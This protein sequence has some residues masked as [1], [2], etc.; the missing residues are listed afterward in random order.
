[1]EY[2]AIV[3]IASIV[4]GNFLN[5]LLNI[6]CI[7]EIIPRTSAV[8]QGVK[9]GSKFWDPA[10]D[11][12]TKKFNLGWKVRPYMVRL[13]Y[14]LVELGVAIA[15]LFLLAGKSDLAQFVRQ[16]KLELLATYGLVIVINEIAA[17]YFK[18]DED[19]NFFS[20]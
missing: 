10:A 5:S 14:L 15:I 6:L 12:L 16:F 2:F 13:L 9:I 18:H 8:Y 11:Y 1:M 4:G 7:T 3:V 19:Q 17:F 20:Y